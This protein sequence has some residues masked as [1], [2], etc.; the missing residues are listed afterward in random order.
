MTQPP[1]IS[2]LSVIDECFDAYFLDQFGVLHDGERP[3]DG[4]ID[5]LQRL[6]AAGKKLIVLTNSGKRAAPNMRRLADVGVPERWLHAVVSSGEVAWRGIRAG[7]FDAPFKLGRSAYV[8]GRAGEDYGLDDLDLRFTDAP[9]SADFLLIAGSDAPATSLVE[10]AALLGEAARRGV[11]ALCVNPDIW[12]LIGGGQAP[13]PGAIAQIYQTLGGQVTQIGKPHSAIYERALQACEGIP[14]NRI[15][16]VG[17]SIAH[18]V[19]GASDFGI[20]SVLVRTGVL[21]GATLEELGA[22]WRQEGLCPD[23]LMPKFAW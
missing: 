20:A 4:V 6:H 16:A 15:L 2:G 19:R 13:A 22:L 21:A 1:M 12:M 3:Y 11:P 7:T 18:D 23:Y 14:K 10:Y 17:D 8:V 9:E 5:A